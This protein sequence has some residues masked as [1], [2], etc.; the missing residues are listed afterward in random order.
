MNISYNDWTFRLTHLQ[1][2]LDAA[3]VFAAKNMQSAVMLRCIQP[4]MVAS[5]RRFNELLTLLEE[6][7]CSQDAWQAFTQYLHHLYPNIFK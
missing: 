3:N 4:V 5:Y 2:E 7:Q 6:V 1:L